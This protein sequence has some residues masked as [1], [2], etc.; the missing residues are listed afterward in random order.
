MVQ[1]RRSDVLVVGSGGAGVT[2]AVEAANA[3][4]SVTIISKEP[5]GYGDTRISLG[6]MS[7][8]PDISSGDSEEQFAEDMIRGGEGLND[9][10][11]V[12]V[13]VS[14]ALEATATFETFGHIFDRDHDGKLKR[15]E[16]PPG[17]HSASRAIGSPAAGISMGHVMRSAAARAD[18]DVLEETVCSELLVQDG[19]V[20]GATAVHM[21]SGDPVVL[22]AKSTVIAA[23]G[24]GS[25]YYPHTDC[26]PSVTGDSYGLALGAGCELVDMEQVQYLPFGITHPPSLLGAPCG[27]PVVAGPFGK[28]LNNKGELVLENI[29]PMTRAQVARSIVEEIGRGGATEHGGLLLDLRPNLASPQGEFFVRTL[30][31]A[32]API[33]SV[34]RRAYGR[35]AADLEEPWDVLPSAHYNMGGIKTDEWC[36]SSVPTLYA[37]G[38]AQGGVMGGNRLGSTSLTEI[39]VFGKRAGRTAAREARSREYAEEKLARGPLEKLQALRGARGTHRPIHL[40]RALQRLMWERVGPLREATGL[41]DALEEISS[42]EQQSRDLRISEI[43]RCN[44]EVADALELPHM[45]ATARAIAMSAIGRTES[46]G[47]HVRSDFPDRDDAGPVKNMVV[48]MIDGECS[49]R[50][51]VTSE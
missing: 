12:R 16:I 14:E 37:C 17:G 44:A 4:A 41:E 18:L 34:V 6:V 11:L 23:G 13:L 31:K 49:L 1:V 10:R 7:T 3:G 28:L 40:K 48:R 47:A 22:L 27:E 39:F 29:M 46:R 8:S 15:H 25:L 5:L 42:I 36:R 32:G 19:E 26:M 43:R 45:L 24:A 33:L 51:V 38:Q 50:P 30:K 21:P 35:K 2:A 20:V 9:P